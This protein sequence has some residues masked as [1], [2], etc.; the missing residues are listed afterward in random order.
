[1]EKWQLPPLKGLRG[2][3][4]LTGYYWKFIKGYGMIAKPLT[5]LLKKGNFKWTLE[6]ELAFSKLKEAMVTGQSWPY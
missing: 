5:H 3:L 4:G 2:C 1:M 6:A